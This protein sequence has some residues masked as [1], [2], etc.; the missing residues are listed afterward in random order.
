MVFEEVEDLGGVG[1]GNSA[2]PDFGDFT[3]GVDDEG[4]ADDT[5]VFFAVVLLFAPATK[6]GHEVVFGI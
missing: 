6:G 2:F 4:G 1:F 5:D 3:L